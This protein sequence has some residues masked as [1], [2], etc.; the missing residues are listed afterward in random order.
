MVLVEELRRSEERFRVI[1]ETVPVPIL[2]TRKRDGLILYANR[3]IQP[4]FGMSTEEALGGS[5]LDLYA[6]PSDREAL[7]ELL[8]LRGNVT[9][10]ELRA[11]RADG[12]LYWARLSF[13]TVNF[14]GEEAL[15]AAFRD[16][17]AEKQATEEL[18]A[19]E[20]ASRF[21]LEAVPDMLFRIRSDGT[22]VGF[23][24]AKG[25]K[26]LLP[27]D[28]I[29][30]KKI[31]EIMPADLAKTALESVR[32][33][34]DTGE[35]QVVE[36]Q[37]AG[38]QF[39]TRV[40]V[41]GDDEVLALV[42]DITR[43]KRVEDALRESEERWRTLASNV[44][45]L[46]TMIGPDH[47]ILFI[48]RTL[49]RLS[50]EDALGVSVYDFIKPRDRSVVKAALDD[51]F[52]DGRAQT[53]ET[54]G[55]GPNAST[56]RYETRLGPVIKDGDV[57]AAIAV[58]TDV[59]EL[60]RLEAEIQDIRE[61]VERQAETRVQPIGQFGLTFRELTVLNLVSKGKSDKAIADILG[62]SPRT[63]QTHVANILDKM[64]ASTRT[65][66]AVR[67]YADGLID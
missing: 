52:R 5:A 18:R 35:M 4:V 15:L 23:V 31:A 7:L 24:P 61:A 50:P 48:N 2:I 39:E 65:E 55:V 47:K 66:A 32:R 56:S 8:E 57:V 41:S 11:K 45:D 43:R 38:R 13:Q 60:R 27:P 21:L 10:Y 46:I 9:D 26:P 30:G 58:S 3:H 25:M 17:T 54:E 37:L 19:A 59:T 53:H 51:V 67:A 44:P 6:D 33:T 49:P 29:L 28:Q 40:V 63:V 16:V 64:S 14:D 20:A 36:T 62:I 34:L 1:A 42:R 22:Y 12:T